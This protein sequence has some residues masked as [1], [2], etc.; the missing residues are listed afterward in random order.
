MAMT[1]DPENSGRVWCRHCRRQFVVVAQ[2]RRTPGTP[3]PE[4]IACPY[5]SQLRRYILPDDIEGPVDAVLPVERR[6][7][8]RSDKK[9]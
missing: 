4:V 6:G 3:I 5:C 8:A 9:A 7:D 1:A 2:P